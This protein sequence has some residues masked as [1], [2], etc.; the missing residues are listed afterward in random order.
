MKVFTKMVLD[1]VGPTTLG[2][3]HSQNTHYE[4]KHIY[5]L[6]IWHPKKSIYILIL[7]Y[8]T[9]VGL[10]LKRIETWLFYP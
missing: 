8:T 4:D 10:N 2:S 6:P 3:S 1:I 7:T 5:I 9:L